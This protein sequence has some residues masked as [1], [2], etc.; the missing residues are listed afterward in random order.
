MLSL[1]RR[2]GGHQTWIWWYKVNIPLAEY[3]YDVNLYKPQQEFD[4]ETAI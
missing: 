2:E 4:L 1:P 3:G